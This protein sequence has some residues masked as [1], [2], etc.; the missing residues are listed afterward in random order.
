MKLLKRAQTALEQRVSSSK[1][2]ESV[3]RQSNR[4]V[5][6]ITW[7]LIAT[8]GLS[9]SWLALAKT[10]EIVVAPGTLVPIGSV[11]EIQMQLGGIV[12]EILVKDG[13]RV[14]AGQALIKLDTE[15]SAQRLRSI[16][17]NLGLTQRQLE[18][19]QLE[20]DRYK[21]LNQ[22]SIKTLND[23]IVFEKEILERYRVLAEVG[24]SAELQYLQQRNTL[25]EVEGRLRESKLDGLRQQAIL[26]QDIQR[27]K[28]EISSLHSELAETKVTLRYQVLR[29]PVDGV[30]FDLQPKGRGYTGQ[31][32]E[33]LMKIV[34]FNA[35]EAKVEIPSSDIGFVRS[36]MKVDLSIDS[37]PATDF[38]VLHGQ[39]SQLGSDALPP[40]PA[41]QELE[42][43]YPAIISLKS[44]T[45]SLKNGQNLMLQPGMS[46]TANIK[47]RKVSYLQLLIGGFKDK[48]DSLRQL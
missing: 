33:T 47:L 19:K 11:Q 12:S 23:K 46:L 7:G 26:G 29:S 18:L 32:S 44:Q 17:E 27:L 41:K 39:V 38:G 15:A 36:G 3:L 22:D 13:D 30:V 35:L 42:Y 48:T 37:F 40:D 9:I 24:A 25:Q 4:W 1:H 28:A 20:L 43:R 2:N 31:A 45:L 6:S 5:T 21:R 10:E 14:K 34:P 16:N 8:T